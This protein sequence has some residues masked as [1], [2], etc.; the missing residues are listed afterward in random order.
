MSENTEVKNLLPVPGFSRW[1][2]I[3]ELVRVSLGF[4]KKLGK[5]GKAPVGRK[6]SSRM[7]VYSNAEVL[8][9]LDNP[10]T[11]R[12][13]SE[14]KAKVVDVEVGGEDPDAGRFR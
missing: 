12:V 1:Q 2:E 6:L 14:A 7:V 13:E 11:Y 5:A 3:E 8:A 4:W 9:W 10:D